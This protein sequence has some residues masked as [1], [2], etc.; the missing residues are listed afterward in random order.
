MF[1]RQLQRSYTRPSVVS[2]LVI[3]IIA[4]SAGS[5]SAAV[6][7]NNGGPSDGASYVVSNEN[8]NIA[9]DDFVLAPGE[10]V[11]RDIHWWGAYGDNSVFADDFTV[12]VYA[13]DNG[14]PAGL[15]A[16]RASVDPLR[17]MTDLITT[18]EDLVIYAY[19][20]ILGVPIDLNPETTYWL[21]IFNSGAGQGESWRWVIASVDD[22]ANGAFFVNNEWTTQGFEL[23]FNLT[24]DVPAPATLALMALG[25]VGVGF[26]RRARRKW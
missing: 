16:E 2:A 25:L 7:F 14:L 10:D 1:T 19:D 26:Q 8:S 9:A 12:R 3:L 5:A 21:S 17:S 4:L 24:N 6:I 15:V 11:I 23:A 22:P 18:G 13:D 20:L